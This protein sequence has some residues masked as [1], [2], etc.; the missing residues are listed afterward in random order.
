VSTVGPFDKGSLLLLSLLL[1]ELLVDPLLLPQ[2]ACDLAGDGLGSSLS[3]FFH[4][5]VPFDKVSCSCF[6]S[7]FQGFICLLWLAF[8]QGLSIQAPL[9]HLLLR[10]PKLFSESFWQGF[11]AWLVPAEGSFVQEPFG[12]VLQGFLSL[13]PFGKVLQGFLCLKPFGKV[14]QGFLCLKPFGKV[15]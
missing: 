12:K 15:L 9:H 13:K 10:G 3:F 1:E 4:S 6:F 5:A 7:F 2:S 14:L 8:W 11:E